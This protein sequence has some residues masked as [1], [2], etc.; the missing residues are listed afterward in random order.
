LALVFV[1]PGPRFPGSS[2]VGTSG[3]NSGNQFRSIAVLPLENLSSDP[4]QEYFVD[5]MTAELIS[6][7]AQIGSLRIISRTS[8]MHFKG[9]HEPL[10][11][12]ARELNVDAVVEGSVLRAGDRVRITAELTDARSDRNLWSNSYERD[13]HDVLALQREVS[14]A[15]AQQVKATLTA[16]E[17]TALGAARPVDV[18]AYEAY[19]QGRFYLSQR[20]PDALSRGIDYFQQA[21]ARDPEYALA[22][23]GLADGYGLQA[24][25]GV[26]PA[27]EVM[28]KAKAVA[29][30]ALQLDETLAEA[31]TSD[32]YMKNRG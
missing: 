1:R 14:L 4:A 7:L 24:S 23:A 2:K 32:R 10:R 17:R 16:Q 27:T 22:Y 29:L 30:K 11:E 6:D 20:T 13:Q 3:A 31:H 25:Y 12:I 18:K 8:A 26:R 19:L 5:G 21:I 28:P 15:I 9:S